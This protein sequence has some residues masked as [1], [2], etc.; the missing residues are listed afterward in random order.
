MSDLAAAAFRVAASFLDRGGGRGGEVKGQT[1]ALDEATRRRQGNGNATTNAAAPSPDLATPSP[2][3]T[4]ADHAGAA[5]Y[6]PA[7][8]RAAFSALTSTLHTNPHS[9]HAAGGAGGMAAAAASDAV[10]AATLRFL[11]APP[12]YECILTSGATAGLALIAASFPWAPGSRF[13]HTQDN[14][15]S[16]V[17]VREGALRAGAAVVVVEAT[18]GGGLATVAGPFTRAGEC[19]DAQ[20]QQPATASPCSLFAFPLESNFSGARY[21][22]D[23]GRAVVG[24]GA[25]PASAPASPWFTLCD[26][27]KACAGGEPP[28]LGALAS[29][30]TPIDFVPLSFYKLFGA[31]TGLGAL[32]ASPRGL[33]ALRSGRRYWG[34]G[35]VAG[36]SAVQDTAFLRP[37]L[38]G[39]E[40]GTPDFLGAVVAAAGWEAWDRAGGGAAVAAAAHPPAARLAA[41]LAALHHANGR[42]AVVLYGGWPGGAVPAAVGGG[43]G[44]RTPRP[45]SPH[46]A[47]GGPPRGS[48]GQG[49]LVSFN[50]L[51]PDGAAISYRTVERLAALHG[52]LLR[53]G[54]LCN[55][56]AAEAALGLGP[57]DTVAAAASGRACWDG[58]PAAAS[59]GPAG[60]VRASFGRQSTLADA[61]AVLD[62]V[63]RYF[64][65]GGGDGGARAEQGAG[66]LLPRPAPVPPP[67][68]L[69]PSPTRVATVESLWV[70]PL[71]GAAG[72]APPGGAWP[73][74]SSSGK[75]GRGRGGLAWDRGWAVVGRA[76]GGE[77][78]PRP[79][80]ARAAPRLASLT[81][82]IEMTAGSDGD[83]GGGATLVVSGPAGGGVLRVEAGDAAAGGEAAAAW[84]SGALGVPCRLARAGAGDGSS[85]RSFSNEADMLVLSRPSLAGL[86]ARLAGTAGA[87]PGCAA[88]GRFRPNLVL[89]GDN[90]AAAALTPHAEDGWSRI[91][92]GADVAGSPT[93]LSAGPCAR[94]GAVNVPEGG[95]SGDGGGGSASSTPAPASARQPLLAL[96][97]YRRAE[98]GA[99]LFGALF[100]REGEEGGEEGGS[101]I[102]VGDG[103]WAD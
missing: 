92:F 24:A 47:V 34:G 78:P 41:G 25:A 81:A 54:A 4:Y 43:G 83:V 100:D 33:A 26:A 91:W 66:G 37:G 18:E 20:Q 11:A 36:V 88:A 63:A 74:S 65:D 10:R 39:L 62:V 80:G 60:V 32:V 7:T 1:P 75:G 58:G 30:G 79:L 56:G 59:G 35:T 98:G 23:L 95:G 97:Q 5:L 85:P 77:G 19:G 61:D 27:A 22:G 42:R 76:A 38:G 44:T 102:R 68:G 12:G 3:V 48:T 46:W 28:D 87:G 53:G 45:P 2:S 82:R 72:F 64:V 55:P 40:D 86:A 99:I 52:V 13:V 70:Y 15:T 57:E 49:A 16:V 73:L 17:G 14:H 94:C 51:S 89:V 101:M 93:F 71:K 29:G 21:P 84:L 90:D 6:D 96:A 103:V 31:P 8:L 69:R 67:A 50:V 9:Q